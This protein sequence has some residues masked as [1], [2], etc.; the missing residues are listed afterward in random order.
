M[1][2][3]VRAAPLRAARAFPAARQVRYVHVENVVDHTLPTNVTNKAWLGAKMI[4]FG[5]T[6]FGLPFIAASWQLSKSA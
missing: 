2:F 5:V 3:L 1:S 6:G 4:V